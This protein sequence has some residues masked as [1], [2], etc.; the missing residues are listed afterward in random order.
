[1]QSEILLCICADGRPGMSRVV[2]HHTNVLLTDD[3]L[4]TDILVVIKSRQ[5]TRKQHIA[6][7]IT[8]ILKTV[9][10]SDQSAN[11]GKTH[12]SNFRWKWTSPTNLCWYQNIG[13]VAYFVSSQSMRLTDR[14]TD[15]Q[16]EFRSQDRTSIAASRGKNSTID[17]WQ[18]LVNYVCTKQTKKLFSPSVR[19]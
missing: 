14:Q 12:L 4:V 18:I 15:G 5:L 11:S 16:T 6:E 10:F 13:I 9:Y 3:E 8:D 2:C 17:Q 1:M 19:V 7:H